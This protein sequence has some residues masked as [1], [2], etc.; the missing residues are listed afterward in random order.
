MLYADLDFDAMQFAMDAL[1]QRRRARLVRFEIPEPA[2]RAN[3]LEI[4]QRMLSTTARPKL[5]LLT[6][7]SHRTGLVMPVAQIAAMARR[8]GAGVVVD[9]AQSWGQ[10]DFRIAD[11]NADFAGG[12]LHKWI[13]APLGTG[14]LYIKEDRLKDI[15]PHLA[16]R[17]F[18]AEDIRARVLTGTSDFAAQLTVPDAL[19]F[20]AGIGPAAKEARLRYLSNYWTRAAKD[21][22]GLQILTPEDPALHAGIAS[23]RF[24]GKG[25]SAEVRRLHQTLAGKYRILTAARKGIARGD[26][27]RVTPSL[28]NT[29]TELDALVTAL[30]E[31]SQTL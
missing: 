27:I 12:S 7:I 31:I 23:F 26:A 13:G 21:I 14:F 22:D 6:H 10:I 5:L 24:R 20:Q 4:Y 29:E 30:R 11:L 25:S 8:F 17:D 2:T 19:R 28:Y 15:D 3:F 9:V 16:N 18:P 1:A